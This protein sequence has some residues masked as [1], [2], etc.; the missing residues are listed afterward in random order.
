MLKKIFKIIFKIISGLLLIAGL[1]ISAA[2]ILSRV[3]VNNDF[4][5]QKKGIKIFIVSNGVHADI[6]V[7]VE[8]KFKNWSIIFPKETFDVKDSL[9]SYITFGWGNKDFYLNTPTWDDLTL[10]V[11]FKSTFGIGSPAMHVRYL[12]EPKINSEN[13][14]E[15][16]IDEIKYQKLINYIE[17]SFVISKNNFIKINHPGYGFYDRFYEAKGTFS[18]LKTCNVWTINGLKNIGVKVAY[19]SPHAKGLMNSLKP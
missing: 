14:H 13:C 10:S 9:F 8:T 17:G 5:Q 19:W 18:A 4:T 2:F 15:I 11:A 3:T 16:I 12:R 1:Y 6:G 7:P